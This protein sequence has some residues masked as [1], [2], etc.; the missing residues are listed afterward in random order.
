MEAT[1]DLKREDSGLEGPASNASSGRDVN[2]DDDD[3][4]ELVAK[5]SFMA[6]SC[7]S[8]HMRDILKLF[9]ALLK[10]VA[11]ALE[12]KDGECELESVEDKNADDL[13]VYFD[14][15]TCIQ[16]NLILK[17]DKEKLERDL[18]RKAIDGYGGCVLQEASE[19]YIQENL[20][21]KVDK[22]KLERDLQ[23]KAIDGYGGCVLQEASE[24]CIQENLIMKVDKEKLE[25]DLQRKAIDGYGGCVLQEASEIC[26]QENLILK[27][28][29]EKLERDLQRKAHCSCVLQET[30]KRSNEPRRKVLLPSRF[31]SLSM[32][33]LED[34][35]FEEF[36][37]NQ[38]EIV[39]STHIPSPQSNENA[40]I[41]MENSYKNVTHTTTLSIPKKTV[42]RFIGKG[43][44][45]IIRL[46]K[47]SGTKICVLQRR[48]TPH[49]RTIPCRIEGTLDQIMK[50]TQ[51]ISN[52]YPDVII[53][54]KK[55]RLVTP[56]SQR[57][58][59]RCPTMD[60][61]FFRNPF[62]QEAVFPIHVSFLAELSKLNDGSYWVLP[63]ENVDSLMALQADMASKYWLHVPQVCPEEDLV[64]QYCAVYRNE[65]WLRG[66]VLSHEWYQYQV[67]AVD[68][69]ATL[70][71]TFSF[72][73]F[74][75]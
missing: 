33:T 30:S 19:I 29:K 31:S 68:T 35:S 59:K 67:E 63:L 66:R 8:D 7:E 44:K 56:P 42:G 46:M 47:Q 1:P 69:G 60:K 20:I 51:V 25:R 14:D 37:V 43:G 53:P 64:G 34:T 55:P 21:L 73:K 28:D 71:T 23:R 27:V 39:S 38:K 62:I 9:D 40:A 5:D 13:R 15:C 10:D 22:E 2:D 24:I 11:R 17:V 26:S 70:S 12:Q 75:L 61:M 4:Y 48:S 41:F 3:H 16:E 36:S 72:I 32:L 54:S 65:A 49:G 50:A 52:F 45:N 58:N 18:Q 6:A 74:L 57:I